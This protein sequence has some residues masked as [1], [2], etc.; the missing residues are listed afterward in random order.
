MPHTSSSALEQLQELKFDFAQRSRRKKLGLLARVGGP[1]PD[2]DS[3]ARL[4]E[5]L[6]FMRAYPDDR[7]V[8]K[9]VEALL[10]AFPEREDLQA[11]RRELVN[12]GIAG[13]EIH[14]AFYWFTLRWLAE[15]CPDRLRIDWGD[16]RGKRLDAFGER[17]SMLVPYCETL[18]LE[19]AACTTREWIE[20]LKGPDETDAEFLVK[21]YA[22]MRA[23]PMARE[24]IFEEQE[25][26]FRLLPGPD[27]PCATRGRYDPSPIVTQRRP[28][29]RGRKTFWKEFERKTPATRSI[30]SA[31]N[32]SSRSA[33]LQSRNATAPSTSTPI[34]PTS[35]PSAG[36]SRP[37]ADS[38]QSRARSMRTRSKP[39][40]VIPSSRRMALAR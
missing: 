16:L 7:R 32:R 4:H 28:L 9:Q 13:T 31:R 33:P 38:T 3:V 17:L 25:L 23:T 11:H 30:R 34:T 35:E 8:L 22:A 6:C 21:R 14:Y 40:V 15:R 37:R 5:H 39:G 10:A 2:A 12:S 27:T 18:A 29:E 20:R 24:T 26:P 36:Q 19:E 1:L